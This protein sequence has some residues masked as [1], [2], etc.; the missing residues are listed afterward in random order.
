MLYEFNNKTED[1]LK[2]EYGFKDNRD[3]TVS[4]SKA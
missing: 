4:W 2:K 3:W 1:E